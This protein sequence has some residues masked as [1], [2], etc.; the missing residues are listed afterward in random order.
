MSKDEKAKKI[1]VKADK[2]SQ[3][4]FKITAKVKTSALQIIEELRAGRDVK[5]S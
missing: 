3:K 5:A 2:T 4:A 1:R